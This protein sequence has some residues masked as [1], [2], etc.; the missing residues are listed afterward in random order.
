MGNVFVLH[1][2]NVATIWLSVRNQQLLVYTAA[3][4]ADVRIAL[5]IS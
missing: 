3:D 2:C 4:A 5:S 1:Q